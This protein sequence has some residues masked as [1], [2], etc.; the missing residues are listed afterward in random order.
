[1]TEIQDIRLL[2]L[3]QPERCLI[4]LCT[5]LLISG[6]DPL[7]IKN[8][9]DTR[10]GAAASPHTNEREDLFVS[11]FPEPKVEGYVHNYAQ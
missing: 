5:A 6:T 11:R 3:E 4:K 9:S 8:G 1:M 10:T 7:H 2:S